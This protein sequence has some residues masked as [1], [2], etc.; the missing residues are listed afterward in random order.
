M[1]VACG[2]WCLADVSSVSPS[3]EQTDANRANRGYTIKRDV[4]I[5]EATNYRHFIQTVT[6][7]YC[8]SSPLQKNRQV[9]C[10][11]VPRYYKNSC[12]SLLQTDK[13]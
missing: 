4:N 8:K 9:S 1:F 6:W 2:I 12:F 7:V 5:H 13:N 11:K 10:L 3:S